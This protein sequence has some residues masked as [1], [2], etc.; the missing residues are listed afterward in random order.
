ME[1]LR[2]GA[3][4]ELA[5]KQGRPDITL[6]ISYAFVDPRDDPPASL[7]P[8]QDDGK[9]IIGLTVGVTLPLYR[10]R[11]A[12]GV[13]Q[14]LQVRTSTEQ[15]RHGLL[16]AIHRDVDDLSA[17]LPLLWSQ[18]HLLENVLVLQSQESVRS[19]VSAYSTGSVGA[20]DLLDAERILLEARVAAARTRADYR[21]A[22]ARLEGVVAGPL[23]LSASNGGT[24]P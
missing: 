10:K 3:R 2:D 14:A 24:A 9:D 12:A 15:R 20:L 22:T 11:L 18:L 1:M 13:N 4:V 19:I 8:I 6:G 16:L 21:I 17:R 5:R 7:A 23:R